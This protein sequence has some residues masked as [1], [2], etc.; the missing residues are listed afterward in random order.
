MDSIPPSL[1]MVKIYL[2]APELNEISNFEQRRRKKSSLEKEFYE[3]IQQKILEKGK[4][5]TKTV[6][7]V[8]FFLQWHKIQV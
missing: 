8:M 3:K 5:L 4:P 6:P 2:C 7:F 1:V